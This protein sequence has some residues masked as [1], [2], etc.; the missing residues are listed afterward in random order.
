MLDR[1]TISFARLHG[2]QAR[3]KASAAM[4]VT[5]KRGAEAGEIVIHGLDTGDGRP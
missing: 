4:R 1:W 3:Q 5:L 2:S